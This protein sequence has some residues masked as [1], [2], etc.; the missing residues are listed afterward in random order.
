MQTHIIENGIVVNTIVAT[1]EEAQV[2]FPD[3][4]CIDGTTGGIGW[5]WD[6]TS[7]TAPAVP[8]TLAPTPDAVTMRQARLALLG[9]GV[10]DTAD[11]AIAAMPGIEGQA[12][13]IEWEYA[14]EIRRDS[15]LVVEM[16]ALLGLDDEALDELFVAA[17]GL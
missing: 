11:A 17:N 4:T 1:A 9:A 12:A 14:H 6:G 10:L 3:A 5:A 2:A 16:A 13:R 7:L 8:P 15:P